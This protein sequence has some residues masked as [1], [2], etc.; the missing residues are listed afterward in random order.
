MWQKMIR[1]EFDR[2]VRSLH[3]AEPLVTAAQCWL[4]FEDVPEPEKARMMY[5]KELKGKKL[6]AKVVRKEN[7]SYA[8]LY[9]TDAN[10]RNICKV[11]VQSVALNLYSL[12][13]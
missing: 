12:Y 9:I 13:Q 1:K 10:L 8:K 7:K 6:Y 4:N 2:D 3:I 11:Y 5:F